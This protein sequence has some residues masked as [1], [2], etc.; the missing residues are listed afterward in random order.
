MMPDEILGTNTAAPVNILRPDVILCAGEDRGEFLAA[1]QHCG[2]SKPNQHHRYRGYEFWQYK[3]FLAVLSG[4]GTGSLEPLLWEILSPNVVK[5]I[6]LVG[7]AG[8]MPG[9]SLKY[10]I[11][12]VV[13]EASA[14]GTGIDAITQKI[15]LRPQWD[16]PP[17]MA[18][19]TSVSTDFYYGFSPR[20]QTTGYPIPATALRE[21]YIERIKRGTQ[22]VEMEVAQFYF[23]TEHFG[24]GEVQYVA[25]KSP[26]NPAGEGIEQLTHSPAALIAVVK[27]AFNLLGDGDEQC[28]NPHLDTRD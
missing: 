17:T 4:I 15:P 26:V 9:A 19:A 8:L 22:L 16:L 24:R 21:Q 1:L 18:T 27:A 10:G 14:A 7:T 23:F 20:L 13:S 6:V 11:P 3:K 5:R 28:P 25:I 12:F 2:I